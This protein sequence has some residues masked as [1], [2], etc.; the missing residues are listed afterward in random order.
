MSVNLHYGDL[1]K[2]RTKKVIQYNFLNKNRMDTMA[3]TKKIIA[4]ALMQDATST[5]D[6]TAE[7]VY[8]FNDIIKQG[9][10]VA[11]GV[12]NSD[13]KLAQWLFNAIITPMTNEEVTILTT[14]VKGWYSEGFSKQVNGALS[15][16]RKLGVIDDKEKRLN[17][18]LKKS[19]NASYKQLREWKN[20]GKDKGT[21]TAKN[22]GK[23]STKTEMDESTGDI[24]SQCLHSADNGYS[25]VTTTLILFG[26][27]ISDLSGELTA[28]Q[29]AHI[30]STLDNL[31]DYVLKGE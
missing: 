4:S 3:R 20:G 10:T 9:Y 27:L 11:Q 12:N 31:S 28:E 8:S 18:Y 13:N 26:K 30:I 25:D 5:A 2:V 19:F 22:K 29:N 23:N 6:A 7:V 1:L 16:A 14:D 15:I 24:I 17:L 21:T